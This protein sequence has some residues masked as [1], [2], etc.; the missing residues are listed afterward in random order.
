[1]LAQWRDLPHHGPTLAERNQSG[2]LYFFSF[3][4]GL[5]GGDGGFSRGE[6][7]FLG[8]GGGGGYP[9]RIRPSSFLGF[10]GFDDDTRDSLGGALGTGLGGDLGVGLVG[11]LGAGLGGGYPF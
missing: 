7:G 10:S 1:M 3:G 4:G 5:A 8:G 11:D 9:S 6:G 2:L